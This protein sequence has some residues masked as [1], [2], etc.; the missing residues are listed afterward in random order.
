MIY[1][2]AKYSTDDVPGHAPL[3]HGAK[4]PLG[5]PDDHTV[6]PIADWTRQIRWV[7][8]R[9]LADIRKA[10]DDPTIISSD[11]KWSLVAPETSTADDDIT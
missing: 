3:V 2:A 5:T 6:E 9:I 8:D 1:L 10:A 11:L 7:A 4:R